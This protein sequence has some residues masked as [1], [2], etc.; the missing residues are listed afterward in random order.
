M[1]QGRVYVATRE[2]GSLLSLACV[3]LLLF[4]AGPLRADQVAEIG[5]LALRPMPEMLARWD[6]SPTGFDNF[7]AGRGIASPTYGLRELGHPVSAPQRGL[8]LTKPGRYEQLTHRANLSPPLATLADVGQ[9][10]EVA[11]Y[12]EGIFTMAAWSDSDSLEDLRD[13]AVAAASSDSPGRHRM[14]AH[15]LAEFGRHAPGALSESPIE[16]LPAFAAAEVWDRYRWPIVGGVA[17]SILILILGFRQLLT[18]R[19]LAAGRIAQQQRTDALTDNTQYFRAVMDASPVPHALTD[20]IQNVSYLNPAFVRTFGY[21]REDIPTLDQWWPKAYPDAAYRQSVATTWIARLERAR[22]ENAPFEPMEVRIHCK[23]GSVRTA[24]AEAASLGVSRQRVHLVTLYDITQT[25]RASERL[26]TVLEAAS[27]GV[28]ILDEDGNLVEF[29]GSFA[30]MLGYTAREVARLNVVDWDVQ[31]PRENVVA[32]LQSH[33]R[34]AA[35]FETKHRRKD[36]SVFE[37]EINAKAIVLDGRTYL[38]ASS[39][40]ISARKQAELELRESNQRFRTLFDL[41]SDPVWIIDGNRFVDCN[42]AAVAALGYSDKEMLLN[43]HP[44]EIS[45]EFQPDGEDS[46]SKA[47][48]M[49]AVANE[50]GFHRFEWVHTRMDGSKLFAEVTLTA[51]VLKNQQ[52]IHCLWRDISDRKDADMELRRSKERLE[53]AAS[54]GIVGIWD[55]DVVDGRLVW[56]A[57]M[58]QLY[59]IQLETSEAAN[60][61]WVRAIHPEDKEY[62]EAEIQAALRGEREYGPEFRVIWPD[63]SIHF[64]KAASKT[65]FDDQGKPL[66]MIGVSYDLTGQKKI[67][68]A[69]RTESEKNKALLRNASDGIHILDLA[70]DV[71]EASDAF[72]AAL[73][74]QRDELIGMN[75][76]QWNAQFSAADLPTMIGRQHARQSRCQFETLHRRKDGTIVHAEVSGYPLNVDGRSVMFYSSRDITERRH[77]EVKLKL[78][79]SVFSHAREGIMITKPDGEIIDVNDSFCRITGYTRDE[80]LGKNPRILNSGRHKKEY[81]A[82]MW[83]ELL[84]RGHWQGEI[85]NRGKNGEEFAVIQTVSTVRD[86]EGHALHY[87]AVFS[88]IT[89]LKE[90]ERKLERIAH[91]DALTGLPNRVLLADRLHQAMVQSKR[92]QLQVAVAYVDLDG[93]KAVNDN[94]GHAVGDQLLISIADRMKRALRDSDT[95]ARLGGDEFV[96]VMT[97]LTNVEASVQVLTRLLSVSAQPV[98]VGDLVL[99][100]SASVGVAFFPQAGDVDADQLIRQADQAMYQ[101]K[102]AGKNQYHIF[103][104]EQDRSVRGHHERLEHVQQAL[105]RREFVLH[106]QPKINLRSG[107]VVGAEAL[108]RWQHPLRGL[109]PPSEFL[110]AIENHA[111]AIELGE[112]VIDSALT[113]LELWHAAGFDFPVSVNIG[114]RQLQQAEFVDRLRALLAK[115]PKVNP[116]CLELEVLE[117]SA[118]ADI[119]QVSRVIHACREF[120]VTFAL[121]DFG[122]GY[123]SLTYL[124][125]LPATQLKIDKSFVSGMLDDP[126]DLAII[127]GI[128]GL[129]AAFRRLVVAEGV[130][131]AEHAEL[132]VRL[133]CELAQGYGIARPMPAH[134][135][136]GWLTRWKPDPAWAQLPVIARED[137]PLLFGNAEHR[138]WV[139]AT[140]ACLRGQRDAPPPLDPHRCR[141]GVWM[142]TEGL[143]RLGGQP[144][145]RGIEMLHAQVHALAV[146]LCELQAQGRNAEGLMRLGELH[147][148]RDEL[149]GQMKRLVQETTQ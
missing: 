32:T 80:V 89:A 135:L 36:G 136:Q 102:L 54:A 82:A 18:N 67:E 84:D 74:Y 111:M 55:W 127:D 88:D 96:A 115:H 118:L 63:G 5:I 37:A 77:T 122:T 52:V 93:F 104:D 39:R 144:A 101:A 138:A 119:A 76:A 143:A 8:V 92:H 7:I 139:V 43:I 66:R 73:G 23:D 141:F 65:T 38:Y 106:Y 9:G 75:I 6:A 87:I 126:D 69:L 98:H 4:M 125:R 42:R 149:L 108:V 81:F 59:G 113:Q 40:D 94:H 72:C 79:A 128:L 28:H 17:G 26:E 137:L 47:G 11:T 58:Y 25:K 130:E 83:R 61:V 78:A 114:A 10:E 146:E 57:V 121:D 29:S 68:R 70:G 48:R 147:G 50:K 124:R 71:I 60:E 86:T 1:N 97:D 100:V 64:I 103:D 148:L 12:G 49:I 132:L 133:G 2:K 22:R 45:P 20:D 109:L 116:S 41:S 3:L 129:A 53:A 19:S 142:D 107:R 27:D 16:V 51:I 13:M 24:L 120:G 33:M 85:W 110:P 131:T 56:D 134:E 123:S 90:H 30:H 62:V 117:T 99:Q 21:S 140:E 44:S 34:Q 105:T 112:W 145:Y 14:R 91:Y 35:T 31:I 46:F 95:V 15:G